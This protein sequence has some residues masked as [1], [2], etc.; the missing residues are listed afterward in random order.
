MDV[1]FDTT[2]SGTVNL[3]MVI[4]AMYTIICISIIG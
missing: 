2:F 4:Y 1:L 3:I